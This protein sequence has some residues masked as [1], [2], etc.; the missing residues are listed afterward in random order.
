MFPK[1]G[2]RMET[3]SF[4]EPYLAYL[5]GS[6]IKKPLPPPGSPHR[7][8]SK[9]DALFLEPPSSVS[10]SLVND[11]Q[12]PQR[13]P[14]GEMPDLQSL[15]DITFRVSSKGAPLQFPLTERP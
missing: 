8:S 2:A 14:Y 13:G 1:S 5:S 11:S 15:F 12:V 3:R 4:T 9:R 10:Q 7:A 6:P